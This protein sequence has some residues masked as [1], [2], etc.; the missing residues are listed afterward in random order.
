MT[1]GLKTEPVRRNDRRYTIEVAGKAGA[2]LQTVDKSQ[3]ARTF[4]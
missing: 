2:G 1:G 3:H 4:H